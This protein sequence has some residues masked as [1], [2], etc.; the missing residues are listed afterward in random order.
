MKI[1]TNSLEPGEP[2]DPNDS[3]V[4]DIYKAFATEPQV[5]EMKAEFANGIAWGTAKQMLFEMV[6]T[7]LQEPREK[8]HELMANPD[9]IEQELQ[10]G[11]VKAREYATPFLARLKEAVGIRPIT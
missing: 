6:N 5:N 4:F 3:Y 1:K 9:I 7:E 11:A 10:K 2:K 8:Y